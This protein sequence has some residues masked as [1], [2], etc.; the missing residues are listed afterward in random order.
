MIPSNIALLANPRVNPEIWHKMRTEA[1]SEDIRLARAGDLTV[2]SLVANC[3]LLEE[4][5]NLKHKLTGENKTAV[6]NMIRT[7]LKATQ[8]SASSLQENNQRR[9]EHIREGLAPA[10]KSLCNVPEEEGTQLFGED[11]VKQ[12][13]AINDSKAITSKLVERPFLEGGRDRYH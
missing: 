3:Q 2:K 13:K 9:R 6:K 8:M 5:T 7:A 10:Y 4:L 12:V 11:L 1:R